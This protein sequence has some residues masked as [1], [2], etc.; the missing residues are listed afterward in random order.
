MKVT[1]FGVV[2]WYQCVEGNFGVTYKKNLL[3]MKCYYD[4]HMS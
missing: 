4:M 2:T 1:S 3:V